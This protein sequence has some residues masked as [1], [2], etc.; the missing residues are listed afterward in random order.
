MLC[1]IDWEVERTWFCVG[2]FQG[3]Q[4][5]QG[6][7]SMAIWWRFLPISYIPKRRHAIFHAWSLSGNSAVIFVK[8][9][10]V[11]K[12]LNDNICSEWG[13]IYGVKVICVSLSWIH[14][15]IHWPNKQSPSSWQSKS[16]VFKSLLWLHVCRVML[17]QIRYLTSLK[18]LIYR[19][20]TLA[21]TASI[22]LPFSTSPR[23]SSWTWPTSAPRS[24]LHLSIIIPPISTPPTVISL[25]F[26]N[27]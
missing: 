17:H 18:S 20:L 8:V 14:D 11:S 16:T 12:S 26:S 2:V 5:C 4:K 6:V 22:A 19:N 25:A 3:S 13:W 9:E 21:P 7:G 27:L 1:I 15:C 10:H 24:A 23:A